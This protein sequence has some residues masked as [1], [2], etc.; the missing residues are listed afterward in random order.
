MPAIRRDHQA[1]GRKR[2][3]T[4]THLLLTVLTPF[5]KPQTSFAVTYP[6]TS[7]ETA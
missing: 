5:K 4:R 3:P 7:T 6:D 2:G 1:H